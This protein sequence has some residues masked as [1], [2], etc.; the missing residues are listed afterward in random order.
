MGP[1]NN[2]G[3]IPRAFDVIFNSV[4]PYLGKKYVHF[5]RSA[6][7][8]YEWIFC[9]FFVQIDK[10]VMKFNVKLI[11]YLNDNVKK[12]KW[13][14]IVIIKVSSTTKCDFVSISNRMNIFRI[15]ESSNVRILDRT[16][17]WNPQLN[18]NF[19]HFVFITFVEIYNNYIYDLFDD[20]IL[21]K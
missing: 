5:I 7:F 15:P 16:S 6:V 2:P 17:I 18:E 20:D 21:N 3:L 13:V 8:L 9:S 1:S 14:K 4:G 12:F 11:Y 19:S 10:I